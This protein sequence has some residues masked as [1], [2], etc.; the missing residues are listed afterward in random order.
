MARRLAKALHAKREAKRREGER[1][2]SIALQRLWR[3]FES[4]RKTQ[5]LKDERARV[6]LAHE[7]RMQ[8]AL[9]QSS[10]LT[11]ERL[12]RG[13]VGRRFVCAVREQ[14]RLAA[15]AFFTLRQ[16]SAA[17]IQTLWRR[18]LGTRRARH[19]HAREVRKRFVSI[20]RWEHRFFA[21]LR[22]Q[23]FLRRH[24]I[25]RREYQ[26]RAEARGARQRRAHNSATAVQKAWRAYTHWFGGVAPWGAV[27][28][29]LAVAHKCATRLSAMG[30][31]VA[32]RT[33]FR[34]YLIRTRWCD[35]IPLLLLERRGFQSRL[36]AARSIHKLRTAVSSI[37]TAQP[38][39]KLFQTAKY[40]DSPQI[41]CL[42]PP[43]LR[44]GARRPF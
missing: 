18:I 21:V 32:L 27:R 25:A 35:P 15:Q 20:L 6:A 1:L 3:G 4:R 24:G 33:Q 31:G 11:I 14:L 17:R 22:I 12:Y 23:C 19:V 10:A 37:Q 9:E 8:M 13:H 2:G 38:G 28:S 43:V 7:V 5:T 30:R 26:R 40:N 34:E 39:V 42:L 16:H 29:M 44:S 41:K 36:S